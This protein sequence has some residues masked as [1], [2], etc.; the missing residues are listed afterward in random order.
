M[1]TLLLSICHLVVEGHLVDIFQAQP[2]QKG[3][4][5]HN[6]D[7]SLASTRRPAH[8]QDQGKNCHAGFYIS[9][10]SH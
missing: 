8:A 6:I 10:H 1:R 3:G 4:M 7:A 9:Y 5:G 2:L